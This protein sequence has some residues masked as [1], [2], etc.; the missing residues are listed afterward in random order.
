MNAL[1]LFWTLILWHSASLL[2]IG[3]FGTVYCIAEATINIKDLKYSQQSQQRQRQDWS[4]WNMYLIHSILVCLF[5]EQW[6]QAQTPRRRPVSY[7]D[8]KGDFGTLTACLTED[9]RL[10]LECRYPG[11]ESGTSP[12]DCYFFST[13]PKI[14]LASS[15]SYD[16]NNDLNFTRTKKHKVCHLLF[17]GHANVTEKKS[18]LCVLKRRGNEQ[19]ME[20]TVDYKVLLTK[21][22]CSAGGLTVQQTPVLLWLVVLFMWKWKI[23]C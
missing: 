7:T 6:T 12:F 9:K 15:G 20:I 10:R 3:N 22:V 13:E 4:F 19:T 5:L 21:P 16:Q 23:W 8:K 11:C 2:L 1:I 14:L 18:Y 17:I